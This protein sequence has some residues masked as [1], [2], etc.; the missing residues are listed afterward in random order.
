MGETESKGLGWAAQAYLDE[1]VAEREEGV[2]GAD[3]EVRDVEL[4]GGSGR[5]SVQASFV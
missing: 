2:E 4:R 1:V 3:A 5:R